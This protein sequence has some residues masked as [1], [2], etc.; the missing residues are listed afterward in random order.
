MYGKPL[1]TR[2]VA[3]E[4]QA[5]ILLVLSFVFGSFVLRSQLQQSPLSVP[6]TKIVR[7]A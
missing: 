5:L 1:R 7:V 3:R 6:L 2:N 4:K